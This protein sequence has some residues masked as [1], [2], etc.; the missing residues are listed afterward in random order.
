[1]DKNQTYIAALADELVGALGRKRMT[2]KDLADA[3]G[4]HENTIGRYLLGL[5]DVP[6]TAMAL[7]CDALGVDVG[8][9]NAAARAQIAKQ[10]RD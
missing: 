6:F 3:T 7:M 5:R 10:I 4:L 8:D 9:L 2:R 1:M